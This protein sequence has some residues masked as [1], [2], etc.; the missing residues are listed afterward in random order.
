MAVP[1]YA[2]VQGV[3]VWQHEARSEDMENPQVFLVSITVEDVQAAD[4]TEWQPL[5]REG[6]A[7]FAALAGGAEARAFHCQQDQECT[8]DQQVAHRFGA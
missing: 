3:D 8:Q 7:A 4:M 5:R 1:R 6:A 2:K